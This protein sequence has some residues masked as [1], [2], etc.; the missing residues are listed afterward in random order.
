MLSEMLRRLSPDSDLWAGQGDD[1]IALHGLDGRLARVSDSA[2][3]VLGRA[4][5]ELL[6]LH[7]TDLLAPEE[8]GL[9]LRALG[10]AASTG[11]ARFD[12]QA[13]TPQGRRPV[14]ISLS[15]TARGLRSVLRDAADKAAR[16]TALREAGERAA[17]EAQKRT[18]HLVNVSHE[19]RTPLSAVIGFADALQ[20]ES[21]GPVG[22]DQY[23]D[24]ARVIHDS[25]QHLL[26]LVTDLLD[27]SKAEANETLLS[28]EPTDLS[29]LVTRC[30]DIVRLQAE[31][32]GLTLDVFTPPAL[33]RMLVDP[34]IVRQVL[35]NL[36]SNAMK[37]TAEGGLTVAVRASGDT[38]TLEVCDTGVGMSPG[39]LALVGQRFKQARK[40]G[41]R[42]ARGTGIG[43]SLAHALARVHGGELTLTSLE[44]QGTTATLTLPLVRAEDEPAAVPSGEVI[45]L[46]ERRRTA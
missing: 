45:A 9:V 11:R 23:R 10:E 4:P 40:E 20:R 35:L 7:L 19:I 28:V 36:L 14:E 12:A 15:R 2:A 37:F 42:G 25:G 5:S 22:H 38:L 21:F 44:A 31:S 46:S 13:M 30:S 16:L 3:R 34:K 33:P 24:Y 26:S 8:H 43:L 27:L 39:D 6:G 1:V 29:E 18:D 41:V 17:R 32:A